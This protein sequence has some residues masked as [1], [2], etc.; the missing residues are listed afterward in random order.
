MAN[1]LMKMDA[2][3]EEKTIPLPMSIDLTVALREKDNVRA[4]S[5]YL[6]I[7][8]AKHDLPA[9]Q[10]SVRLDRRCSGAFQRRGQ[11]M[12]GFF[13]NLADAMGGRKLKSET[14]P[15]DNRKGRTYLHCN[16]GSSD[17]YILETDQADK[18][19]GMKIGLYP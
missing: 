6:F 2:V 9:E 7:W 3:V 17:N 1:K 13:G 10:I 4:V 15:L 12:F 16:L 5:L 19:A 11:L 18:L 14:I 8:R